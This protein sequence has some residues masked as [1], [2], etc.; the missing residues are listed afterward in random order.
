MNWTEVIIKVS[1]KDLELCESIAHMVVPYGL[2]TE[3]Y[4]NLEEE[5]EL[6]AR[7][8]L[9]DEDL[10][11]KDRENAF[12]HIYLKPSDNPNEAIS[13]LS[14]RLNHKNIKYEIMSSSCKMEDYLNNWKKYFKPTNVGE[15]LLICPLWENVKDSN[16]RTV[17]KIEPG[18]A[19]GTGTHETTRLCLELLE[20]YVDSKKDVLDIGCGSGILSVASIL[21]GANSAVGV[22][23]DNLAIKTAEENANINGVKDKFLAL[24][25]DLTDK[26]DSKFDIIL[27]NIVAD[28]LIKLNQNIEKYMKKDCIYIISGIIDS[29][30]EDVINSLKSNFKIIDRK[31][32]NGWIALA[33][34][35]K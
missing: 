7:I 28:V 2:Y 18:L 10:L 30:E 12:I 6:I 14:E 32:D 3:D 4:S 29:R 35:L 1:V 33:I 20:K 34:T 11:K 21:L 13:F 16:N 8:N 9:I 5:T 19:F 24:C 25:A 17:L 27:A 15:K 23:I 26:I 31:C 22:D